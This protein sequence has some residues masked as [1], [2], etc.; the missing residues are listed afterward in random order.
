M[1][2]GSP[3]EKSNLWFRT[4]LM[5]M[6]TLTSNVLGVD[7]NDVNIKNMS[8]VTTIPWLYFFLRFSVNNTFEQAT[9]SLLINILK[10]A[11]PA[12]LR[13][14]QRLLPRRMFTPQ[15]SMTLMRSTKRLVL[16][17]FR[18]SREQLGRHTSGFSQIANPTRMLSSLNLKSSDKESKVSQPTDAAIESQNAKVQQNY[19][20]TEPGAVG[21]FIR[22]LIGGQTVA[23]E[24]AFMAEAKEQGVKIPSPRLRRNAELVPVKRRKLREEDR[25]KSWTI[26]DRLF[27]RFA[28][29]AF[30]Q[31]AF[32]AKERIAERIDDSDNVVVNMFRSVYD[33]LFAENE[34]AMVLREI[35]EEDPAFKISDFLMLVET[36]FVPKILGAYLRGDQDQLRK[37]CTEDAFAM[38]NASIRERDAE[39]VVMD[40]NILDVGDV[41]LTAGKVLEDSSVL[42]VSFS[43]QQI[44]CLRDHTGNVIE[45]REDDIRAVYYA[46]AFV[47]EPEFEDIFPT[48][49]GEGHNREES[50]S[51]GTGQAERGRN[52]HKKRPWKLMEMVIR[53]THST[54]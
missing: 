18:T 11:F 2:H 3:V 38:L 35:C 42:I 29:S 46:W 4:V 34:M 51:E 49:A 16:L 37:S 19:Q 8:S 47:K 41:E 12:N 22:G 7:V 33:R 5:L 28:G 32:N 23:V 21:G 39:G 53:A 40:P 26:R 24:D 13:I 14:Q 54:I 15:C 50:V 9:R 27:S 30:M 48:R 25:G 36:D 45:G 43:T 52:S 31:S 6:L 10:N 20:E 44:N 17:R 1:Y